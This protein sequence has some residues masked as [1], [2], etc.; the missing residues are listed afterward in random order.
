[1]R[2]LLFGLALYLTTPAQAQLTPPT[3]KPIVGARHPALSPDG[4]RLAF[5][6]RGDIWLADSKGG[7]A[8]PLTF[9]L[10]YDAYPVFSPDGHWIAFASKRHGQWDIFVIPAEGGQARRLTW[11]SGNEIPFG[12]SP[13][14]QHRAFGARRDSPRYCLM[15]VEV[16]TYKSKVKTLMQKISF[17]F[18][19]L[20]SFIK[21]RSNYVCKFFFI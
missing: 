2:F 19:N 16:S 4:Q 21:F 6:Y 8:R 5:V 11:H 1:M 7:R 17:N 12:W 18:F 15:S 3:P 10:E 13:N 9:H 14:G 20:I